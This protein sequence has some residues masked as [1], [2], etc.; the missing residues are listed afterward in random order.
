MQIF[1]EIVA[2]QLD[3][4]RLSAGERL[5]ITKRLNS[6]MRELS[7]LL[8]EGKP[9]SEFKKI[10]LQAL[11]DEAKIL[12]NEEYEKIEASLNSTLRSVGNLTAKDTAAIITAAYVSKV[13]ITLA[14]ETYLKTLE[15]QSLIQ[16]APS[17]EWWKRQS[18]DSLQKFSDAVR[19]GAS[20][21]E[22]NSQIVRR[23]R[24]E[25]EVQT[26]NAASLVQTSISSVANDARLETFRQNSDIIKSLRQVSTLDGHTSTTCVAYSGG[27]WD[28]DGNPVNGTKLAF[29]GGP[30][31]HWR[32]RSVLI[33]ITKTFK[34]LG[35]NIPEP[36]IGTRA[37]TGGPVAADTTF[38]SWLKRRTKAQQDEQL[39]EGRAQLWRDGKITLTDLVSGQGRPLSLE[40]LE[41]KVSRKK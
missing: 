8:S 7:K 34:E 25:M 40:E 38:D 9:I 15:S 13:K 30:P 17:S 2:A 35:L 20:A 4:L 41:A 16:G 12:I 26:R 39:G 18:E 33:P 1:D 21:G 6:L 37:A 22:T 11:L 27:E 14:P 32:C 23:V 19:Q 3:L 36:G 10:R 24:N 29:N 31:R 28:L 5:R